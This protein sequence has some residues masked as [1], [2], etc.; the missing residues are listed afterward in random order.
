MWALGYLGTGQ[1][2]KALERLTITAA[3]P[4]DPLGG[5][6]LVFISVN[7]FSDPVLDQPEFAEARKNLAF[8]GLEEVN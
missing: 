5:K 7:A 6:E 8:A 1:N 3:N 2:D 4:R